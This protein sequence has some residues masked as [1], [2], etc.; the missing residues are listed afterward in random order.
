MNSFSEKYLE[1]LNNELAG[2]NLTR[3]TEPEE[4]HRKQYVDSILPLEESKYFK[5]YIEEKKFLLDIGFGGGFPI[6]PLAEQMPEVSFC[7]FEARKKKATAVELVASL[8]DLKNVKTFHHRL[9]DILIDKACVLTAKAVG[10]IPDLLSKINASKEVIAYF[11]KGP[12]V[13][14]KEDL[15]DIPKGWQM[16]EKISYDLSG[17][18][19]RTFIGFANKNVPR[20]TKKIHKNLVKLSEIL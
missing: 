5:K 12:Q 4:F 6:L 17:L 11:Y 13:E 3:I 8:M 18:D 7:G 15:K 20:G 14:E 9:E 16:I 2:L 1:I 19:H 10:P